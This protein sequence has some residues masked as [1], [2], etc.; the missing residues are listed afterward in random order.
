MKTQKTIETKRI[1]RSDV[2]PGTPGRRQGTRS[3]GHDSSKYARIPY[4][5]SSV[6]LVASVA[7]EKLD[8]DRVR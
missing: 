1:E 2:E 5:R 4:M 7:A 3:A 8:V 6:A